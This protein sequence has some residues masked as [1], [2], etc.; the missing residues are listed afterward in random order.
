M[1]KSRGLREVDGST[2]RLIANLEALA[3]ACRSEGRRATILEVG[4]GYGTCLREVRR[5][6]PE[7]DVVGMNRAKHPGQPACM[8]FPVV[9]VEERERY[10]D[11]DID[12]DR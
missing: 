8:G 1:T 5:R 11:I 4:C 6:W 10:R 12:I 2:W 7:F 9:Y 3:A